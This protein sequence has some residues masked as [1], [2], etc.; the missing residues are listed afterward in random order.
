M[1]ETFVFDWTLFLSFGN[2][3]LSSA[4]AILA[5]SLLAYIL[6]Y[7]FHSG[8]ARA[9]CALLACVL[10]VYSSDILEA[11][12]STIAASADWLRFQ[13]LGLA[14]IPA[15]YLHL[16]SE[17]LRTTG[18]RPRW[19]RVAVV[20][21][22]VMG[23]MLCGLAVGTDLIVRGGF[24]EPP[25]SR[26]S[27]GPL[28]WLFAVYYAFT[29]LYGAYNIYQARQRALT[30]TVRRRMTYLTLAFIGPAV[31]VFPYLAT[32]T[33]S[34]RILAGV[35]LILSLVGNV[36]VAV[37]LVVM[38]YT[39]AYYGALTPDRV[40]RHRLIHYLLR[41]PLVAAAVVILIL[42]VPK[43]EQ[44]LDLPR[45]TVVLFTVVLAIVLLELGV[46]LAKPFIDRIIYW[47]DQAEVA[48][49]QELD[50]R[51]LT[52]TDLQQFLSNVLVA[53]CETLRVPNA[54][55]A[56]P[57]GE[58]RTKV[59][60]SSGSGVPPQGVLIQWLQQVHEESGANGTLGFTPVDGYW[61]RPLRDREGEEMLGF[62]AVTARTP[63]V[64]LTPAETEVLV[65][66]I[67]QAEL[68][69]ADRRLQQSVFASLNRIMPEIERFQQLGSAIAYREQVAA[70]PTPEAGSPLAD[71][72]FERWVKEA[73]SHYWGG[74]K[75]TRS[76]LLRL[77]VVREALAREGGNPGRALRAV[78]NSAIER[79][80]PEGAR[81]MAATDWV[82]YNILELKFIQGKRVREIAD[83]L[84][85]SESDLYRKQRVAIEEVARALAAMEALR[86]PE[87][88]GAGPL[89]DGATEAKGL[90]PLENKERND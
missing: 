13:W 54:F 69:L 45:D 7:N 89:S 70:L 49:I 6:A 56:G 48:W 32:T 67:E 26:L 81:Q 59:E 44:V 88:S 28:F 9:F 52:T 23:A 46:N 38:A 55:I 42:S 41:G 27:S 50:E 31:G 20:G 75:L 90:H 60:V 39:I 63:Q 83:R 30:P 12:A 8:V 36:A 34:G 4:L 82:L 16:A 85:M 66:L 5:L 19:W 24:Y 37:T 87:K 53:I 22:Y 58:E 14:F 29:A 86:P 74:P 35:V 2:L 51:L 71:P 79:L 64:N 84:A 3:V 73:L 18:L 65:A 72:N 47:Q 68:A 40:I 15:A 76:P 77:E 1:T 17:V 10:V 80:R 61:V 78:L 11:R 25:I 57:V 62:L 43:I 21:S 33:M